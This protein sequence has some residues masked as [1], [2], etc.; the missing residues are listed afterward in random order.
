MLT[1]LQLPSAFSV[2]RPIK[3][4]KTTRRVND[5]VIGR[6]GVSLLVSL[7][8]G[9]DVDVWIDPTKAHPIVIL[10]LQEVK[11]FAVG[12]YQLLMPHVDVSRSL[13]YRSV[14]PLPPFVEKG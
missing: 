13:H 14:T 8:Q 2:M 1:Y 12:W 11:T 9:A 6:L 10:L 3:S 7:P 5:L 4:V